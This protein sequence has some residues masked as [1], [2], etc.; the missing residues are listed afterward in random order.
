MRGRAVRSAAVV[1]MAAAAAVGLPAAGALA[2]GGK[3]GVVDLQRCLN[4]TKQG[5]K[6][7]A[8]FTARAEQTKAELEKKEAALKELRESLEKQGLVLSQGARQE[9]EKEYRD[10]LDAFKEQF[11]ASQQALQKQ[12]QELTGRIL[13]DLQAV[14][15]EVAEAGGFSLVAERQEGGVLYAA[16][17]A[18]LTDEVIR[19]FDQ[20]AKAE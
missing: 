16:K 18:D 7:R 1:L 4:E 17:D 14:V 20:K 3:I 13:K 12:D 19:R 10:R 8:D 9:K 15:R 2:Q 5:K 11:K 6:Y